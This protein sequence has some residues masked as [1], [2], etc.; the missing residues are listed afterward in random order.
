MGRNPRFDEPGRWHHVMNRGIARRTLFETRDDVRFFLSRLARTV[1]RGQLEVHA[2]CVMSTHFHLLV[3]S[4]RG[5]LSSALQ[6][7]QN[8]YVRRFNRQRRRD[9]SLVRGRFRSKPVDSLRY[10]R[11]LV[12]YIDENPVSAGLVSSTFLYPHGSARH[13]LS[14]AGPPWLARDWVERCV[15]EA[16]QQ[17]DYS[18][19]SYPDV[20][21]A[22]LPPGLRRL[23]ERRLDAGP[24]REDPL[25]GLLEAAAPRV[26]AWMRRK[27]ELADG[28]KPGI[29]LVDPESV[30]EVLTGEA[31][32]AGPWQVKLA[33]KSADAWVLAKV[34]LLRELCGTTFE[35]AA[36]RSD[37]SIQGAWSL[38][39]RHRE[40]VICDEEYS[41]RVADL[42][43]KV[44]VACHGS[45][46]GANG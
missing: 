5:E 2:F 42:A 23:I 22:P 1:R 19:L 26:R 3:R 33:R 28:T 35:E 18:P 9:G 39:R 43:G 16:L 45:L 34:A 15:R 24:S 38:Y 14:P 25:D 44:L 30:E 31:S 10:R 11:T 12:R 17:A 8:E 40:L 37:R 20:F 13:Y 36:R 6:A 27:A 29:P 32:I 41:T 21:G 4:P 7:I 46:S